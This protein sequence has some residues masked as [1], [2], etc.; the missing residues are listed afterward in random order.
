MMDK[1][2]KY[3]VIKDVKRINVRYYLIQIDNKSYIIEHED[4]KL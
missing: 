2:R 4:I 1:E 3:V